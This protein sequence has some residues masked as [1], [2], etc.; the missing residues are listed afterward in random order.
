[1]DACGS[2]IKPNYVLRLGTF[3]HINR[4]K[5][6]VCILLYIDLYLAITKNEM[7]LFAGKYM[8]LEIIILKEINY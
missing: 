7:V 5:K 4:Q 3:Q 2:V 1:M 6:V 8:K